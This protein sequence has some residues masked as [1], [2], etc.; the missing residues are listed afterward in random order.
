M[1]LSGISINVTSKIQE[2]VA[3]PTGA[4]AILPDTSFEAENVVAKTA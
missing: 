4:K 3:S 1:M 2:A